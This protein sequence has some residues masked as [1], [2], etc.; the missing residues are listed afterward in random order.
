MPAQ[1]SI[2][3]H[4]QYNA[5]DFGCLY[6]TAT[7]E[8]VNIKRGTSVKY[9]NVGDTI[10]NNNYERFS[11]LASSSNQTIFGIKGI[12]VLSDYV[13]IPSNILLDPLHLL[14]E[15]CTKNLISLLIHT[16]SFRNSY[17]IGRQIPHFDNIFK[18]TR[19]P[20]FMTG[21]ISLTDVSVYSGRDFKN[22][23]FYF[24][25]PTFVNSLYNKNISKEYA[26]HLLTFS[27]ICRLV[28]RSD[29]RDFYEDIRD[30]IT[31]FHSR[32]E[33]LY[34][35]DLCTMNMHLLNHLALQIHT[36]GAV[37]YCSMFAFEHQ[38]FC[39]KN[40]C[41]GTHSYIEQLANKIMLLKHAKCY[42]SV[43]YA[44][45]KS[46]VIRILQMEDGC[47]NVPLF[48]SSSH[49]K[50]G[51]YN[52]YSCTRKSK[53]NSYVY[54]L[55]HNKN[56]LY[57]SID[58]FSKSCNSVFA[59]ISLFRSINFP[60]FDLTTYDTDIPAHILDIMKVHCAHYL[61]AFKKTDLSVVINVS[62]IQSACVT[63][64]GFVID[65]DPV[66]IV[67]PCDSVGE[68]G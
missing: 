64:E 19:V 54:K 22:F 17:Y 20:H 67:L 30:L 51:N 18:L 28:N 57:G 16:S 38:F 56:V 65:N 46:D 13:D 23:I 31:Y 68:H 55:V 26:F 40:Y 62:H 66:L 7:G 12:S 50:V 25:L 35:V 9:R 43:T 58:K 41:K 52:Y 47:T 60:L 1:A 45:E 59:H 21:P 5:K 24:I 27:I 53:L 34:T 32:L 49:V 37:P 10:A 4:M 2:L 8:S 42:L 29:A 61:L 44:K 39:Y 48:I 36:F 3:K 63:V 33:L 15:N 14:Y 6:C 11:I